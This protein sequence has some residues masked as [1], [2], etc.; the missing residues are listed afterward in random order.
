MNGLQASVELFKSVSQCNTHQNNE[1]IHVSPSKG[2]YH[3]DDEH[4]Y[5]IP[6]GTGKII[7]HMWKAIVEEG[8]YTIHFVF[9]Y[10]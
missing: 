9:Y 5:T 8:A 4:D 2:T 10:T 7:I 6:D 3:I 1:E